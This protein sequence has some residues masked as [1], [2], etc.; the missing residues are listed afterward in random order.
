MYL[1]T[2]PQWLRWLYPRQLVWDMPVEK[3]EKIIYL[4]FDDGPHPIATP[5][6]LEQ[7]QRYNAKATFFCI[8]N[9]V[10]DHSEVYHR[11]LAEGHTVGNH[12]HH[13]RNGWKTADDDYITDIQQA[14]TLIDSSLFRPPYG[15]I[16]RFQ[17]RLLQQAKKP[18][19]IIMWS[20]LAADW[21]QAVTGQKCYENVI[22]NARPGSII[23]FHDSAKALDRLQYALPRVL[24]HFAQKGYRFEDISSQ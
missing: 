4:T 14:A 21:D 7:L 3:D 12:T 6:V 11:I 5:F 2:A 10:A 15:R 18:Y 20:V 22:L 17:A 19:R 13:H 9:N 16:T 23:V 1:V 24:D 8:G